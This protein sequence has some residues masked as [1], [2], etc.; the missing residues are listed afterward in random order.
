[1]FNPVDIPLISKDWYAHK[2][3][4]YFHLPF[5]GVLMAQGFSNNYYIFFG[6]CFIR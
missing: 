5:T 4:C 3:K 6:S 1:M 2:L